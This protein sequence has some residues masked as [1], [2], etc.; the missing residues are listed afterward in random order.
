MKGLITVLVVVAAVFL[1]F[2]VGAVDMSE[3]FENYIAEKVEDEDEKQHLK[4]QNIRYVYTVGKYDRAEELIN[5]FIEEYDRYDEYRADDPL[6]NRV[7]LAHFM[8][9]QVYD[10]KIQSI[11][12]KKL[13]KSYIARFPED[14]NAEKARKRL[15]EIF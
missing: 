11:S 13:Y 4:I 14:E 6:G 10:R 8:L 15:K 1:F 5:S 3:R 9:A 2:V 12:A 7:A